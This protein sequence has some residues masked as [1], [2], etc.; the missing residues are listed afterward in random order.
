VTEG[1]YVTPPD[2][3]RVLEHRAHALAP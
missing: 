2:I 1:V 3:D